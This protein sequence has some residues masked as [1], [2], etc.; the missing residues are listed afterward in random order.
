[1]TYKPEGIYVTSEYC[2]KASMQLISQAFGCDVYGQY[3]QTEACLFAWTQP[4]EDVYYCSPYYGYVEVLDPNTGKHVQPGE[5]GEVVV[6]AFGND[7]MPFI[8][9]RTG[10]LVRYGGM[11]HGVVYLDQLLGRAKEYIIDAEGKVIYVVGI[12]S[13]HYLKCETH[14]RQ[15]QIEQSK[16][17]QIVFRLAVTEA[18]TDND[19]TEIMQLLSKFNIRVE[20]EYVDELALTNKG[21]L[22]AIIQHLPISEES[23]S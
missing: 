3:G 15:Y 7:V 20:F 6:T 21:K 11:E 8:R 10:D 17:G 2:S 5:T 9:Y 13:I 22:R 16:P 19:E 12:I 1:M 18:W 4:N 14:I 23:K